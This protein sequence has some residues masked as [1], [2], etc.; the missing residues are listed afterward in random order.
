MHVNMPGVAANRL[1]STLTE[2][3]NTVP[4]ARITVRGASEA[5]NQLLDDLGYGAG[6]DSDDEDS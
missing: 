1:R 5:E 4:R 2:L 6:A 3:R